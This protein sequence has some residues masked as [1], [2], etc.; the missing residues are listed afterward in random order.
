MSFKTKFWEVKTLLNNLLEIVRSGRS[1]TAEERKEIFTLS[2]HERKIL[3]DELTKVRE[4]KEL[5]LLRLEFVRVYK[6]VTAEHEILAKSMTNIK[7]IIEDPALFAKQ[8][9]K[10]NGRMLNEIAV[11]VYQDANTSETHKQVIVEKLYEKNIGLVWK[12]VAKYSSK[13]DGKYTLDD[14][15]QDNKL[16]FM[17]I[18]PKFKVEKGLKLSTFVMTCLNNNILSVYTSTVNPRRTNE[19]SGETPIADNGGST[20]TLMDYQ[21]DTNMTPHELIIKESENEIIYDVLNLL[22][23]E[24]KFIAYCRFGLGGV[25]KRTQAEIAGYM[26]MSQAN[27][28]KIENNM[29]VTLKKEL[30]KKGFF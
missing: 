8:W 3:M 20:K 5:E 19:I 1:F 4:A 23:I 15:G 2:D 22:P 30:T 16:K 6:K 24:Q 21:F 18:L 28:S 26:H 12:T 7:D 27:V 25:E 9:N 29:L 13:N 17:Q 14:L 11:C 10:K